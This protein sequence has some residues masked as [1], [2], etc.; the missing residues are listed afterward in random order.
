MTKIEVEKEI[1]RLNSVDP[2]WFCPL[3]NATCRKDCINFTKPFIFNIDGKTI[4]DVKEDS[5]EV[6]G[7]VCSNAQYL[8]HLSVIYCHNC[9]AEIIA[10]RGEF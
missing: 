7:F 8:G 10:G 4:N 9:G 2:E 3:L 1:K 5:F 6:A